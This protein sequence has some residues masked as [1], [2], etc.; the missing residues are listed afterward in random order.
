MNRKLKTRLDLVNP[1]SQSTTCTCVEDQQLAQKK[2]H[3]SQ[4]PLRQFQVNDTLFV[5][6]FSYGPKW[7]CG[8]VIQ[9][10]GRVS[11]VVQ[12]TSGGVFRRHVDHSHLRSS[13][14]L[15]P[16]VQD[17]P[18]NAEPTPVPPLSL[19][20]TLSSE[21]STPVE[22]EVATPSASQLA[23]VVMLSL[24]PYRV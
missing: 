14:I 18:N 12:L 1:L 10:S 9:T 15:H 21:T 7:L 16:I 20:T 4:V 2:Q 11:Y 17:L 24:D 3:D 8:N 23:V 19:P 5:K 6:N 13:P 22:S